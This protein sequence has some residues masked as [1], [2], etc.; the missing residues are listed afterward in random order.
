MSKYKYDA[1]ELIEV[2]VE[3]SHHNAAKSYGRG[4]TPKGQL[5]EAKE[6]KKSMLLERF[7]KMSKAYNLLMDRLIIPNISKGLMIA[8][9]QGML[10]ICV[11]ILLFNTQIYISSN[12][13]QLFKSDF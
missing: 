7:E 6:V 3:N 12:C 10:L 8:M 5:I 9:L 1:M 4:V 13:T 11:K 2:V